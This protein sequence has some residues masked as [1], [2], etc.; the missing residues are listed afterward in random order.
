MYLL[1]TFLHLIHFYYLKKI[2][3]RAFSFFSATANCSCHSWWNLLLALNSSIFLCFSDH[4]MSF[5][6]LSGFLSL[7]PLPPPIPL[8][9]TPQP[10][11]AALHQELHP[12]EPVPVLHPESHLSAGQ[13]RRSL[14]QFEHIA[15]SQPA[16][17][18]G[19]AVPTTGSHCLVPLSLFPLLTMRTSQC[20]CRVPGW[21]TESLV[22][23]LGPE[24]AQLALRHGG[25][26]EA[27]RV[28]VPGT[29]RARK[30]K[31]PELWPPWS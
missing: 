22:E 18:L 31:G 10:Q 21:E 2:L 7:P 23:R 9:P 24:Q 19:K 30:W 16:V 15:L 13:G 1:K 25:G 11:E 6:S 14:L 8:S 27:G 12:S 4:S 5:S 26:T 29:I 28:G 20:W 3:N 17:L